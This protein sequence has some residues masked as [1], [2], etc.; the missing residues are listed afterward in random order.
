MQFDQPEPSLESELDGCDERRKDFYNF[1]FGQFLR[2]TQKFVV[3]ATEGNRAGTN[4]F[5]SAF[6]IEQRTTPFPRAHGAAFAP[7]VGQLQSGHRSIGVNE[8]G[9]AGQHRNVF[10]RPN[11]DIPGSNSSARLD[12]GGF[13][14]HEPGTTNGSRAQV[15][16]MPIRCESIL[17]PILAHRGD[18]D[19]VAQADLPQFP[20][21]QN[22]WSHTIS[23]RFPIRVS[24]FPQLSSATLKTVV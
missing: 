21:C 17:R 14:H 19:A 4:G 20:R 12:G 23:F 11:P 10:V 3:L 1:V 8:L 18:P 9:D 22:Q 6:F 7:S 5:P 15:N 24:H 16:Q 2:Y 13:G